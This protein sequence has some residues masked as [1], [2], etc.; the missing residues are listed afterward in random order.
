MI[1]DLTR[2]IQPPQL[3]TLLFVNFGVAFGRLKHCSCQAGFLSHVMILVLLASHLEGIVS[4][5]CTK[6]PFAI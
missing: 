5:A 2:K 6:E 3:G 1:A 4:T